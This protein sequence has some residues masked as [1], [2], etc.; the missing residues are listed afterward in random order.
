MSTALG[1]APDSSG[2]G[3]DALTHRRVIAGQWASTGIVSGLDVSGRQDLRYAVSPGVAVCSMGEADGMSIAY[4]DGGGSPYTENAVTAGDSAYPRIDAIYMVS[5]TGQP[6]NGVHVKVAQGTPSAS[7]SAPQVEA[8]GLVLA[9]RMMPAGA[10]STASA[11]AWGYVDYAISYEASLGR[12]A[13]YEDRRRDVWGDPR[14]RWWS[15]EYPVDFYLP[16][17]RVV[18]LTYDADV[19]YAIRGDH[20]QMLGVGADDWASWAVTFIL[21]GA[22]VPGSTR[23]TLLMHGVWTH[24]HNSKILTMKK[25]SHRMA[26]R[27]GLASKQGNGQPYMHYGENDGLTYPGRTVQV[28][29]RGPAR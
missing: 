13:E 11:M 4:W 26:V 12:L 24:A 23:E 3:C 27:Q 25:G 18:E 20:G 19:A 1:V 17:D 8:G 22:D 9:Y 29:D 16:T 7:P 15:V 6:D 14:V 5:Y 10:M 2:Q 21:D 28:W